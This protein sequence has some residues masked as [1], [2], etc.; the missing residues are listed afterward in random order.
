MSEERPRRHRRVIAPGTGPAGLPTPEEDGRRYEQVLRELG[1][2]EQQA[3]PPGEGT[4][5][6]WLREQRPPHWG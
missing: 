2:D 5:D 3:T 6:R 1:M 4:Q